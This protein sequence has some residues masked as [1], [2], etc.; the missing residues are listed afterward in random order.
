[1]RA[2]LLVCLGVAVGLWF[3]RRD[4]AEPASPSATVV[5]ERPTAAPPMPVPQREL[6]PTDPRY[7]AVAYLRESAGELTPQEIFASEPRDPVV[8]PVFEARARD[9]ISSA[10]DELELASKVKSI[11]TECKTLSCETR[12]EVSEEEAS[13]IYEAVNGIML[14]DVQSPGLE[15]DGDVGYVTFTNL[16]S[17]DA[18]DD[19]NH[20]RFLEAAYRPA[21]EAAKQRMHP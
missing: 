18:R 6:A 3:A 17:P 20:Q 19:A 7:D 5:R 12:L 13:E 14:G 4:D 21:L 11:R 9:A 10:L 2:G 1:M 15:R 16:Y 8:A